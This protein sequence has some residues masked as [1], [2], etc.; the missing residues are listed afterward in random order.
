M[1]K[2]FVI[3]TDKRPLLPVHPCL[4]RQLLRNKKAAVYRRFPFTIILKESYADSTVQPLRL[5]IDPDAN[6]NFTAEEPF[7]FWLQLENP[8][9]IILPLPD[10][11]SLEIIT[12]K[13]R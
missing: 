5:K 1:C 3:D 2:V 7:H 8:M 12:I 13:S 6:G 9:A 4:A 11:K 10:L